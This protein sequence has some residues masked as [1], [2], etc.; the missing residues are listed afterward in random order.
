[1]SLKVLLGVVL[2]NCLKIIKNNAF[3]LNFCCCLYKS[4]I[5]IFLY[6]YEVFHIIFMIVQ[7]RYFPTVNRPIDVLNVRK[8]NILIL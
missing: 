7:Y 1:M 8:E 4:I 2:E 3:T 6:R 5:N